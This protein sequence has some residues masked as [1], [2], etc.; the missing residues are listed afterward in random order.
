M[1][2]GKIKMETQKLKISDREQLTLAGQIRNLSESEWINTHASGSLQK[3]RNL[4]FSYRPLYLQ[5]RCAHD[6]GWTFQVLPRTRVT[7]GDA[8]MEGDCAPLTETCWFAKRLIERNIFPDSDKYEVKYIK[9][10]KT[11]IT[12]NSDTEGVGVVVRTSSANWIPAGH[13]VF[14]IIAEWRGNRWVEAKNPF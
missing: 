4:G 8:L 3:S 1:A 7:F 14:A 13:L 2:S 6:F 5:E 9:T 10:Y 12:G 11:D